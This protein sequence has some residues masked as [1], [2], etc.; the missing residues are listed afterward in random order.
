MTK[1]R[2]RTI[3]AI[4]L[5]LSIIFFDSIT[6]G[7]M[8]VLSNFGIFDDTL[9]AAKGA[10][11][12][13]MIK[14]A[15]VRHIYHPYLLFA[16]ASNATFAFWNVGTDKYGFLHNGNP[17]SFDAYNKKKGTYRI[18][19]LGG[20]TAASY[21]SHSNTLTIPA[22]LEKSL[23]EDETLKRK[24]G[25]NDF[26]VINAARSGYIATQELLLMVMYLVE[27]QPDMIITFDGFNEW[28]YGIVSDWHPHSQ[29]Y[30]RKLRSWFDK[31][32]STTGLLSMALG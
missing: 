1:K 9:E 30:E 6:Y 8:A 11:R 28:K 20:S 31:A 17:E 7:F 5:I 14:V 22:L 19:L 23:R 12:L 21:Q 29:W 2:R 24:L 3:I 25:I 27:Y 4:A 13:E 18:F 16:V 10:P 15:D 26:E 32:Q